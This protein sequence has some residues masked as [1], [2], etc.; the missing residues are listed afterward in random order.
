M[1]KR[2]RDWRA[3]LFHW[4]GALSLDEST[5][6][7]S[8]AWA[9]AW[10]PSDDGAAPPLAAHTTSPNTF[11]CAA[12]LPSAQLAPLAL[13]SFAGATLAMSSASY[14]L[15]Q[16]DGEGLQTFSDEVHGVAFSAVERGGKAAAAE[17]VP[18]P[19]C[20]GGAGERAAAAAAAAAATSAAAEPAAGDGGACAGTAAAAGAA[21]TATAPAAAC[22]PS[23]PPPRT[24]YAAAQGS[25]EFG[26]FISFGT[27]EE[28][29]GGALTLALARRYLAP[30]DA[31]LAWGT[32][33][34]ALDG[35]LLA[36][37]EGGGGCEA[38]AALPYHVAAVEGK[39][40]SKRRAAAH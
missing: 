15:D 33:R 21:V 23:A 18:E 11:R 3:T 19:A 37:R 30:G 35:C 1:P 8:L 34:A 27:L 25:T 14:L 6:P 31:R 7:P 28:A 22:P 20:D 13:P 10:L 24:L 5:A 16:G 40:G 9:G 4:R 38:A 39:G 17:S 29:R 2:P 26:P 12:P 36:L 32:P